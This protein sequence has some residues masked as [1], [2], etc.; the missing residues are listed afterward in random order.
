MKSNVINSYALLIGMLIF[1]SL[2]ISINAQTKSNNAVIKKSIS[3]DSIQK[4]E[5]VYLYAANA[6]MVGYYTDGSVVVCP[7]C[8]FCS[9]NILG[10]SKEQPTGKWDLK[11]P[12][13]FV[14]YEEDK[15]WVLTNYE[16]KEKV[17]QF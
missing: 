1:T 11:K 3:N 14:S 7:R 5:L 4:K 13:N 6:G 9:S 17:P 15:G 8:D 16:W 2:S 12:E 10:M